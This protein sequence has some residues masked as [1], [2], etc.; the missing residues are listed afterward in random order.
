MRSAVRSLRR[1]YAC[2]IA[3]AALE[4]IA[5]QLVDQWA[6]ALERGEPLP[7]LHD[8][9]HAAHLA[10]VPILDHRPLA[11]YLRQCER[12]RRVPDMDRVI[13]A[14]VHALAE[15]DPNNVGKPCACPAR[16]PL[17][18]PP[19]AN[20]LPLRRGRARMAH[21]PPSPRRCAA[22]LPHGGRGG[23]GRPRGTPLRKGATPAPHWC[24]GDA[25]KGQRRACARRGAHPTL[26]TGVG[27]VERSEG[28]GPAKRRSP[29]AFNPLPGLPHAWG[30]GRK[31]PRALLLC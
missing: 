17:I 27:R 23:R 25:P 8:I 29:G 22:T 15:L 6:I 26:P 4:P 28:R 16:R 2:L 10:G 3:Q 9:L 7:K 11:A 18:K 19:R 30:R 31:H 20:P 12:D 21:L 24:G 5:D 13:Y 1:H 14:I